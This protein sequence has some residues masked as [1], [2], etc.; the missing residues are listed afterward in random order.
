MKKHKPVENDPLMEQLCN[1]LNN[2][3]NLRDIALFCGMYIDYFLN[4]LVIITHPERPENI[5]DDENLGTYFSKT[6]ILRAMGTLSKELT[7]NILL[8]GEIRNYF[9][10]KILLDPK[11]TPEE[12]LPKIKSLDYLEYTGSSIKITRWDTPW[13]DCG[14]P[15]EAQLHVCGAQIV[16]VLQ[17]LSWKIKPNIQNKK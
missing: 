9:A 5:I 13:E 7:K 17:T 4:E 11:K 8:I 3:R 14:N 12:I 15:L 1:D 6:R 16:S 10:H 2:S